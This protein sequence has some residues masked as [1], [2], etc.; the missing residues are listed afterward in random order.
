MR[1]SSE[2]QAIRSAGAVTLSIAIQQMF[3]K[4]VITTVSLD[5]IGYTCRFFYPDPMDASVL[6]VIE[7]Q[8][9]NLI[10]QDLEI[11]STEML[12]S[13]IREFY[14]Y[15]GQRERAEALHIGGNLLE[16]MRIGEY[17]EAVPTPHVSS[18]HIIKAIK[19]LS[20]EASE[21]EITITGAAFASKQDLKQFSKL[22]EKANVCD[23]RRLGRELGYYELDNGAY[24]WTPKGQ[25]IK[26]SLLGFWKGEMLAG[27]FQAVAT[28]VL[29]DH[30][31]PADRAL[32]HAVL[33]SKRLHSYRELPIRYREVAPIAEPAAERDTHGLFRQHICHSDLQTAF[34]RQDQV[35]D[36]LISSLQSIKKTITLFG[37]KCRGYRYKR[38]SA[39]I[40]T[41][42]QWNKADRLLDEALQAVD[43]MEWQTIS[44]PALAGPTL[45]VRILDILEREWRGPA[46]SFDFALPEEAGLR[47]QGKQDV[48]EVPFL[49]KW[50]LFGSLERFIALLV[51]QHAGALPLWLAPEQIRVLP[52]NEEQRAYARQVCET[53]RQA[54]LRAEV[55]ERDERLAAKVFAAEAAKIALIAIV[56]EQEAQG[57]MVTVRTGQRRQHGDRVS[58]DSLISL[59]QTKIKQDRSFF[60]SQ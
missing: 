22:A 33:F 46:L 53:C 10:H 6:P 28:P 27:G 13:N 49:L 26:E 36:Q 51:E 8:M 17:L 39:A 37:L 1:I 56:G 31:I 16:V 45:E 24:Y 19:L 14:R 35:L 4:A 54:G 15:H 55:D 50:T 40:G 59:A 47:Y 44:V 7:R 48:M 11:I 41:L 42:S 21:G 20:F 2:A 23:H 25:T 5:D 3:P 38:G 58:I 32:L 12:D 30:E 18:L 52:V 29:L 60:E 9:L 57:Q 34:C 43:G